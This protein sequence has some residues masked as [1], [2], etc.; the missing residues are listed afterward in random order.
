MRPFLQFAK[1]TAVG[2]ARG[3]RCPYLWLTERAFAGL[4]KSERARPC[5]RLSVRLLLLM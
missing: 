4:P 5:Q 3:I 1:S 2:E